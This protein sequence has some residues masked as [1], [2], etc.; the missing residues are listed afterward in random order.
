VTSP[1]VAI[2]A[3]SIGSR[4]ATG[5]SFFDGSLD[6]IGIWNKQ[7]T[8]S[9]IQVIYSRQSAKYAGIFTSRVVSSGGL[10]PSW[11]TLSWVTTH[12]FY[13]ELPENA[14]SESTHSYISLVNSSLMNNNVAL[15]HLD[16]GF[17]T[18]G[19]NS[20]IDHSGN[21]N[22][23]TPTNVTF[24]ANGKLNSSA[25]FNG[26]SSIINVPLATNYT[27]YTIAMW[28][29]PTSSGSQCMTV[30]TDASGPTSAYSHELG[31]NSAGNFIHY[32]YDQSNPAVSNTVVSTTNVVPGNWYHLTATVSDGGNM[33]LYVNGI[34]EGTPLPITTTWKSATQIYLGSSCESATP[35]SA[36]TL[37]YYTGF[38]DEVGYWNRALSASEVYDLYRRGANRLKFQIKTCK[39]SS[40]GTGGSW[41]GPDGTNQTY[42]SELYDTVSNSLGGAVLPT[43]ASISYSNLGL[44]VPQN[45]YLQYRTIFESEDSSTHCLY[46]G[47]ST[48]CSPELTSVGSTCSE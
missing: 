13:K 32:T 29:Q 38:M 26:V 23:G 36:V 35:P 25:S 28:V 7:L 12:P 17:G 20:V 2:S 16:E 37:G 9:E 44:A 4:P 8:P 1:T 48:W 5:N 19:P 31:V 6:E 27:G 39:D 46:N 15:W 21:G 30:S 3:P 11:N 45:A 14:V 18:N 41:L 47:S 33:Y 40:C 24:G 43:G 10:T 42:F 34:S 22:N